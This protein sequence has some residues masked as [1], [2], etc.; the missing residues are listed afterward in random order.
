[1]CV[2]CMSKCLL[3]PDGGWRGLNAG[4]KDLHKHLC[5]AEFQRENGQHRHPAKLGSNSGECAFSPFIPLPSRL[6]RSAPWGL[7][8]L[9]RIVHNKNRPR[10]PGT[11]GEQR[12]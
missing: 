9:V 12:G 10:Y 8:S 6:D 4:R 11:S 2:V 7:L 3:G 1:M 5:A